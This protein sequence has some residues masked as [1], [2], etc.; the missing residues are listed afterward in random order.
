MAVLR[1]FNVLPRF[2]LFVDAG[3]DATI[4]PR[5][6]QLTLLTH[7]SYLDPRISRYLDSSLLLV[8]TVIH[9]ACSFFVAHVAH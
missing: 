5:A 1:G 6:E 9:Q 3:V 2:C 8:A 4:L 7:P